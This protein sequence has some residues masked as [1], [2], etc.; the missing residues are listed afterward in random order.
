AMSKIRILSLDGGG[1]RG[2]IPATILSYL[3]DELK[4][5]SGKPE[6]AIGDYFDFIT[7]TSTGG[8]LSLMYLCPR[9][10][11]EPR[12]SAKDA[13]DVYLKKGDKIFDV[14][15]LKKIESLNG[16]RDEKY[17]SKP[18][19]K[20]LEDYFGKVSLSQLL[21]PCLIPSYDIRNRKAF[22]FTSLEARETIYDFYLKDVAR[23]ASAAPTY[24]EVSRIHSLHGAPYT[25]ID[26]G[27]FAN[28]PALCAY[29]EARKINFQKIL[30][31]PKKP[32]KPTAREMLIISIGTGSVKQPYFYDDFKNAGTLEWIRPLIDIMMSGNSETVD[33]QLKRIY[34]TLSPEDSRDY[35]RIQPRLVNADSAMDN[36]RKENLTALHEDGLLSIAE[37]K[38]ELDEIVNKLISNHNADLLSHKNIMIT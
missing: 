7:G 28:N 1:I 6:A 18:L 4:E 19:E 9:E 13:L 36:A 2:I 14:S 32:Q 12:Y 38:P 23:A 35:H 27:V 3:E 8:I 5:K 11:G 24:F 21:K 29:A 37:H 20:Q 26:G 33:Y 17:P 16:I 31:D 15:L 25:L 34:E 10:N 22:F 30:N